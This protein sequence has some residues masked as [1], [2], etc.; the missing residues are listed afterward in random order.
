[1]CLPITGLCSFTTLFGPTL[2][3]RETIFFYSCNTEG[4]VCYLFFFNLKALF[5]SSGISYYCNCCC[6][7]FSTNLFSLWL[8]FSQ[9]SPSLQAFSP[10]LIHCYSHCL[11]PTLSF[12]LFFS[13]SPITWFVSSSCPEGSSPFQLTGPGEKKNVFLPL[14]YCTMFVSSN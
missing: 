7:S 6:C 3:L 8:P 14:Y 9:S 13:S 11:S 4:A 12:L 1:M 2:H 5:S 10:T